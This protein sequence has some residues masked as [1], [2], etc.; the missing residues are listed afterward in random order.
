MS[1]R[2]KEQKNL[3]GTPCRCT[4]GTVSCTS[5]AFVLDLG[6]QEEVEFLKLSLSE[7]WCT[8]LFGRSVPPF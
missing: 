6:V 8:L 1:T 4:Y 2:A 3:V 5:G 7:L